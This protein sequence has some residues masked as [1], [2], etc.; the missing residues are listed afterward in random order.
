MDCKFVITGKNVKII[1]LSSVMR[2]GELNFAM[3][4]KWDRNLSPN[5]SEAKSL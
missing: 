2:I 5:S 1:Q 3:G 4:L